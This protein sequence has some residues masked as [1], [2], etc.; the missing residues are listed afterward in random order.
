MGNAASKRSIRNLRLTREYH[1]RYLGLW[2]MVTIALITSCN[3]ILYLWLQER[4]SG[5]DSITSPGY[6]LLLEFRHHLAG[7][8][9]IETL[10]FAVGIVALGKMTAHR[11]AGPYLRMKR[12]FEAVRDG[13]ETLRLKFRDYDHLDEVAQ[14]FNEMLDAVRKR[15]AK[16]QTAGE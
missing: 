15:G 7:I 11:I 12:T 1:F 2:I 16:A 9:V 8:L 14:S 5:L 10:I 13:D 3:L 4:F 6:S